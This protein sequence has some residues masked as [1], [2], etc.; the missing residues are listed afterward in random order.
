MEVHLSPRL[1]AIARAVPPGARVIDVGTDHA[2]LP[3]WLAQTGRASHVFASD[4]RPG[5]LENA[6]ALV[7]KTGTGH[8]VR[9]RLADGLCGFSGADGDTVV[10]AGMGGETIVSILS[11]AQWIRSGAA[12]I[13][14]PQ[15][16]P[17][18]LRRWL[19]RN[20][21]SITEELLVKDAG[22][23]Y[24]IL[25]ACGGEAPP[26]SE[27]EL[28]TGLF[29]QVSS[30]PLLGEYL[31]GLIRRAGA[32]APYDGGAAGLLSQYIRMKERLG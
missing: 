26:Y 19:T 5:P 7:E 27:A 10:I 6:R 23:I 9:L 15:T 13:L 3:V 31:D 11:A 32:A 25:T 28:H 14:A 30:Q 22:R 4:I 20:G 16:K 21:F 2:H 12:L 17:E 1:D 24:P 29:P 18:A 8:I